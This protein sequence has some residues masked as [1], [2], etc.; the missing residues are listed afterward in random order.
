VI[1]DAGEKWGFE[2]LRLSVVS[3][4]RWTPPGSQT[5]RIVPLEV[6]VVPAENE[7]H[8]ALGVLRNLSWNPLPARPHDLS[9][10]S[11]LDQIEAAF[12]ALRKRIVIEIQDAAGSHEFMS[13]NDDLWQR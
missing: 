13:H 9:H 5:R 12:A 7:A 4:P 11:R 3:P 2:K 6:R 1:C 10:A 8:H